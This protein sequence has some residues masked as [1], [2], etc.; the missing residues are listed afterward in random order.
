M[1]ILV[2]DSYFLL[3]QILRFVEDGHEVYFYNILGSTGKS[4]LEEVEIYYGLD[5]YFKRVDD[6]G[7]VIDKVDLVYFT[8]MFFP[9][10]A[11]KLKEDGIP[12]YGPTPELTKME[13]IREYGHDEMEKLGIRVPEAEVIEGLENLQK[14]LN[15][16]KG[17]TVIKLDSRYRGNAETFIV[18]GYEDALLQLSSSNLGPFLKDMKFFVQEFIEGVE[19]GADMFISRDKMVLPYGYTLEIKLE[20]GCKGNIGIWSYKEGSIRE[21]FSKILP[22]TKKDDYRCNISYEAILTKEGP[23]IL[24]PTTRNPYPV[25]D[26]YS[27]FIENYS[28]VIYG[29]ASGK[30]V[31]VIY[32]KKKPIMGQVI[33]FVGKNVSDWVNVEIEEGDPFKEGITMKDGFGFARVMV[34]DDGYWIPP[35]EKQ[36]I[37]LNVSGSNVDEVIEKCKYYIDKISA[38]NLHYFPKVFRE[39]K[40][41]VEELEEYDKDFHFEVGEPKVEKEVIEVPV[42]RIPKGELDIS[43]LKRHIYRGKNYTAIVTYEGEAPSI[44]YD[45]N[46]QDFIFRNGWIVLY[47]SAD[48]FTHTASADRAVEVMRKASFENKSLLRALEGEFGIKFSGVAVIQESYLSDAVPHL[49]DIIIVKKQGG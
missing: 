26:L 28:E 1:R 47:D 38:T 4:L 14:Y 41:R 23:Y 17:K 44:G 42:E 5:K 37:T 35:G 2:I 48:P 16:R 30:P 43:S 7:K 11:N 15:R 45:E 33:L 12:V 49:R 13:D 6:Y 25:F 34:K 32:D 8:D 27:R 21:F 22:K 10:L 39:M 46:F 36:A 18:E 31:D 9:D 24:E 29:V 20:G 3:D 40:R 19:I